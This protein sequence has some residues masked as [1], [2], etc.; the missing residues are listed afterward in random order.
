MKGGEIEMR[1]DAMIS[2][3]TEG[4]TEQNAPSGELD[5]APSGVRCASKRG[6]VNSEGPWALTACYTTRHMCLYATCP[7]LRMSRLFL[8]L[9][10]RSKDGALYTDLWAFKVRGAWPRIMLETASYRMQNCSR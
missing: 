6:S 8:A 10:R 9:A 1:S 7:Y 2:V 4:L 5:S 3:N